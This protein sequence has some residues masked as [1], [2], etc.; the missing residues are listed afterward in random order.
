MLYHLTGEGKVMYG[1]GD[2]FDVMTTTEKGHRSRYRI[3]AGQKM[4]PDH[5]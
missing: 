2:K 1:P 3:Y 5:A 4:V